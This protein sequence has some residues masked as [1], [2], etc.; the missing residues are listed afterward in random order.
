MSALSFCFPMA[1]ALL[2]HWICVSANEGVSFSLVG[3]FVVSYAGFGP[4]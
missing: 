3:R 1:E 2:W 4:G